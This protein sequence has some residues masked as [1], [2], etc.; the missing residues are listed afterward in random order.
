[1]AVST[2]REGILLTSRQSHLADC[3]PVVTTAVFLMQNYLESECSTNNSCID[4]VIIA[5]LL[6]VKYHNQAWCN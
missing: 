2:I 5:V 6:W 1:M 3:L 4:S